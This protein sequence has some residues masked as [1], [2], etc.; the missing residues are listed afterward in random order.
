MLAGNIPAKLDEKGRL[1]VPT[2]FRTFMETTW[3]TPL[4]LFVTSDSDSGQY[5]QIYPMPTWVDV[6]AKLGNMPP[7]HPARRKYSMWTNYYGKVAELDAQGRV[8]I[9]P[10][11]RDDAGMA[12][13]V[14]VFGDINKLTVWN[15]ERF[16]Q[17]SLEN[18]Y[19]DQDWTSLADHQI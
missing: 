3:G 2:E 12:G 9:H 7:T 17:F 19:T 4:S 8:S 6:Q 14:L 13:E 16:K 15:K 11:L 10:L 1:K 5:V 18:K